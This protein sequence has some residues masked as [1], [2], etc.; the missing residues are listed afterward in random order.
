MA[1]ILDLSGV[2]SGLD[3]GRALLAATSKEVMLRFFQRV[4]PGGAQLCM[5]HPDTGEVHFAHVVLYK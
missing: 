2:S 3:L 4:L 5:I 1:L